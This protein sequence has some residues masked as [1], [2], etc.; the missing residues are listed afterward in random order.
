MS[1]IVNNMLASF[2]AEPNHVLI[3]LGNI[4]LD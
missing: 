3:D 4:K 2:H 1:Y